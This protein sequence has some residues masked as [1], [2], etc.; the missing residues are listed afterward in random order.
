ME[1]PV[2]D[3]T[4]IEKNEQ[5]NPIRGFLEIEVDTKIIKRI[6]VTDYMH[7]DEKLD[8]LVDEFEKLYDKDN[9]FTK[10]VFTDRELSV[11]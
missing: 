4:E 10:V 3:F 8:S 6:E 9:H 11:I 5:E 7:D 2:D 1:E